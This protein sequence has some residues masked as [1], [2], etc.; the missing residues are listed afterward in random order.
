MTLP[1]HH[2][3]G[4]IIAW[5]LITIIFYALFF[6][7][8][9]QSFSLP[10]SEF[11]GFALIVS[12]ILLPIVLFCAACAAMA[13]HGMIVTGQWY[14]YGVT[15]L[16]SAMMFLFFPISPV[17][18]LAFILFVATLTAYHYSIHSDTMSRIKVR[19]IYTLDAGLG[20]TM[21]VLLAAIAILYYGVFSQ[22]H[23]GN[24]QL[25]SAVK[26][27]MVNA[28]IEILHSRI[29]S[30]NGTVT[31]D[32][33]IANIIAGNIGADIL[34]QFQDGQIQVPTDAAAES[35]K[36]SLGTP[37]STNTKVTDNDQITKDFQQVVISQLNSAEQLIINETRQSLNTSLGIS[38]PGTASMASVLGAVV[39]RRVISIVDPY[40]HFLPAVIA[41]SL[42]LLL[43][44]FLFF[45]RYLTRGF[46]LLW[47]G[48]LRVSHFIFIKEEQVTAQRISLE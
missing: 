45:Y 2:T 16:S 32:Q 31:Y 4:K 13:I 37:S 11:R 47:F 48:I 39:D 33:F 43:Y 22:A 1:H 41:A 36:K 19:P 28:S 44:V 12:R 20:G 46:G 40:I 6:Y 3:L 35:L 34:K 29:P 14:R 26:E 7:V 42:F 30:F 10:F 8:L 18:F 23:T 38:S 17:T 5:S 24:E 25:R 9:E 15:F 27:S 21:V